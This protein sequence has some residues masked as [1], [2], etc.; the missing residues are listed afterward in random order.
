M[1]KSHASKLLA[2]LVPAGKLTSDDPEVALRATGN[3][4]VKPGCIFVAFPAGG[5]TAAGY[6]HCTLE[7]ERE[8]R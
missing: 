6:C 3:R 5:S 1:K 8:Y 4:E 2:G 7:Q